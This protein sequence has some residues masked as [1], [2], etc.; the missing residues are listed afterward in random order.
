MIGKTNKIGNIQ[1]LNCRQLC[2]IVS[3]GWEQ[4]KESIVA[5]SF[6][7]TGASKDLGDSL[8]A[9]QKIMKAELAVRLNS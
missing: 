9:H 3:Q 7:L 2:M 4:T 8:M 1:P 6:K 5:K